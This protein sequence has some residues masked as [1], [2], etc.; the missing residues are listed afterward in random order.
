MTKNDQMRQVGDSDARW[1]RCVQL[2]TLVKGRTVSFDTARSG[3]S[4]PVGRLQALQRNAA[5]AMSPF[6][7]VT[8]GRFWDR[9]VLLSTLSLYD[10]PDGAS[11][12]STEQRCLRREALGRLERSDQVRAG[13]VLLLAQAEDLMPADVRVDGRAVPT[14]GTTVVRVVLDAQVLDAIPTRDVPIRE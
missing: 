6:S 9:V 4:R 11:A 1:C 2:G 3:D 5:G 7:A 13:K 14:G 12:L 10:Q 8:G